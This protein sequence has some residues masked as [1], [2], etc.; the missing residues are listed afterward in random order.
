MARAE[1]VASLLRRAVQNILTRGLHDPRISGL[2]SVTDVEVSPD[3]A[4]AIIRV[5]VLP[6]DR[7]D[8]TMHGLRHATKHIRGQVSQEVDLR[9]VPRL[10]FRYDDTLKRQ[11]EVFSA[12][13]EDGQQL[14][15][16]PQV[17]HPAKD[18]ST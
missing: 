11:A 1:Q 2:V 13:R 12:I 6:A 9:R 14:D 17:E 8:L 10:E 18:S 4:H 3:L 15:S 5:S 16:D 7:A